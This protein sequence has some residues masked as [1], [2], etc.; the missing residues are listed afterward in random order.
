MLMPTGVSCTNCRHGEY[1]S[2]K[3]DV[4]CNWYRKWVG[5]SGNCSN[6]E[7]R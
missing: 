3:E 5:C 1:D 2:K 7:D 6:W 4:W